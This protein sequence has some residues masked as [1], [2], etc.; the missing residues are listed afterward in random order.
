MKALKKISLMLALAAATLFFSLIFAVF[1]KSTPTAAHA[2][3]SS[4][5]FTFTS[6]SVTYD[7][8]SDRTMDVTLDLTVNYTG[9]MSTGFIYDIPVNSGDR[10]RNLHAYKLVNGKEAFLEYTIENEDYD[11]IS[12]YMD[13]YTIKTDETH[14]YRIRYEYAI[15]KPKKKNNILLNAV[16]YG[17]E[18]AIKDVSVVI[19]L[20]EGLLKDNIKCWLGRESAD[21]N[22]YRYYDFDVS[23]NGRTISL[24]AQQLNRYNG[25]TFDLEFKSGA[26][27]VKPDLMP[28]WIIIGACGIFAVL[29]AI[30]LLFF[31][32]NDLTPIP[33]FSVPVAPPE[34]VNGAPDKAFDDPTREMD[35]LIM[36]KL[37]D[38]KVDASDITSMLYYWANKGYIKINMENEQDIILIRIY[39]SL[40]EGS[41]DYQ[42]IMYHGLFVSGEVVHVNK[43]ENKF[44]TTAE[45]VTRK[46][47]A[48]NGKLY[49][50]KSMAVAI[51]FA[52]LGAAAMCLTPILMAMF[53]I[54]KHLLVLAPMFMIVPAFIVFALTQSVKYRK[55]KYSKKKM[56]LLYG[57]IALLSL[58]ISAL[59]MWIIVPS[60]VIELLPS[61]LLGVVGFAIVMMS[62]SIIS[63]TKDYSGKLNRIIG[64]KQFIETVE[65][66]KLEQMLESNPEFYYNVLPYA[67]VLGVSDK[68]EKKFE[69]LTIK[70]PRW[71]T[72]PSGA[73]FDIMI[74]NSV[75][76][77][78][79]IHMVKAMVSRPSSGSHSGGGH[80]IGGHSGGGHGGGGF[81]GK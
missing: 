46:V 8:R 18:G 45:K 2:A 39:N 7:I 44:Y 54:N 55:L 73:V 74:F 59:Y 64:F 42:K 27:S 36:G 13:D 5:S 48:E 41:P 25:I 60:Y 76:R 79:N 29:F 1:N 34:G 35:P 70:P 67:I 31:N 22:E 16:G 6:Y 37:I 11:F 57:G 32:K 53:T 66:D 51:V 58:A 10:V 33:S 80:G 50:G 26:L 19:N 78:A 20:P 24:S 81:R 47:N 9:S 63:R 68:W 28:Y 71:V 14:S 65:K 21:E 30:K 17:S 52:L 49:S 43:L 69:G 40:P 4:T 61:F 72:N 12:V 75:M 3:S 56:A 15:T 23:G 38:N 77:N 62:V